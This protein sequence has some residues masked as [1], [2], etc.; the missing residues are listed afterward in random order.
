[1]SGIVTHNFSIEQAKKFKDSITNQ[2]DYIYLFIGRIEPWDNELSVPAQSDY[3]GN[4]DYDVWRDMFGLKRIL[5]SGVTLAARRNNWANNT[6]YTEYDHTNTTLFGDDYFVLSSSNNVY[7]CLFNNGGSNSTVEPAGT[8]TSVISSADGYKWKFMYSL[9]SNDRDSF[10]STNYMPVKTLTAD[11]SSLQ[12]GIQQAAVNG[13]IDIIDVTSGGTGYVATSNTLGFNTVSNSTTLILRSNAS[14]VDNIYNGSVLRITD[15]KGAGQQ[16][17]IVDYVGTTRQL[18]VNTSFTTVPN[19]SSKYLVSP[20]VTVY[21]D[22][23]GA[24]AYSNV[25]AGAVSYVNIVTPGSNYSTANVIISANNGSGASAIAYIPQAGGH[26]S[27]PIQELNGK[28][29]MFNVTLQRSE[30]NT[31]P[32]VND[33]RRFGLIINPLAANGSAWTSTVVSQTTKLNL[34]SVSSS[35]SFVLDS[36]ALGETTGATAKIVRFANT[37]A[38][39]TSGI[40][41]VVSLSSNTSFTSGETVTSSGANGIISSI[42]QPDLK[43][44]SGE[45]IYI[46]NRQAIARANDQDENFKLVFTL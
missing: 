17:E 36:T 31:L 44:Y 10:L 22:G 32:I 38:S 33:Y 41:H 18:I 46:E 23:I 15:G 4:V 29:L 2:T 12:W 24:T 19:T 8:G 16:R 43:P 6:L 11:D 40:L 13:S 14:G 26:G 3:V 5:P 37:N 20:K 45:V 27:N 39:N 1:M 7:K 28:N 9:S 30:A 42:T 35:G 21:G 25:V 34:T